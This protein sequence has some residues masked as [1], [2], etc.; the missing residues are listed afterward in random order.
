M[1]IDPVALQTGLQV[2]REGCDQMTFFVIDAGG[3]TEGHNVGAENE[4]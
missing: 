4:M 3:V 2:S 1:N